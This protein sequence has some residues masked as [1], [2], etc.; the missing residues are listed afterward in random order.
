MIL[1]IPI[2]V[3]RDFLYCSLLQHFFD[4]FFHWKFDFLLGMYSEEFI[5]DLVS[6]TREFW[7]PSLF[8]KFPDL[9]WAFPKIGL[10][11]KSFLLE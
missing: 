1:S 10:N 7:I 6:L 11:G 8:L 4:L 2:F 5:P 9:F 3:L